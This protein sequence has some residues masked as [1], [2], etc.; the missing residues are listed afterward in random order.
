[1]SQAKVETRPDGLTDEE[2]ATLTPEEQRSLQ[3]ALT[4]CYGWGSHDPD[5]VRSAFADDAVYHDM[6]MEA[7]RG[8]GEI[9]KF[10]A[11]WLGAFP[12][13]EVTIELTVVRGNTVVFQGEF[14]GWNRGTVYGQPATNKHMQVP[15][16]QIVRCR[17][18]KITSVND[19]WD[20]GQMVR[21]LGIPLE[22][23]W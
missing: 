9:E 11:D 23:T 5:R 7:A 10:I 8:I 21:Q 15:Y 17:D 4:E 3:A 2:R 12:E 16:V 20:K 14:G 19:F 18:G 22:S 13:F 6:T 1:M